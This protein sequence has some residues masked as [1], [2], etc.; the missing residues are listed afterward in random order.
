MA[1]H[2]EQ[3]S[4]PAAQVKEP[5]GHLRAGGVMLFHCKIYALKC[6]LNSLACMK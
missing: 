1:A 5:E 6:Q 2:D 3:D 4:R